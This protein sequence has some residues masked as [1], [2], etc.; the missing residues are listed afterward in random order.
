MSPPC[1]TRISSLHPPPEQPELWR[2][3]L[4]LGQP[5]LR[6]FLAKALGADRRFCL[7]A[8]LDDPNQAKEICLRVKPALLITDV[9]LPR[10]DGIGFLQDLRKH[11]TNPHILVLSQSIDPLT[12]HRLQDIGI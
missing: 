11:L 4:L 10:A 8:D 1:F 3:L 2:T 6:E 5:L 7:L 12:L 9:R